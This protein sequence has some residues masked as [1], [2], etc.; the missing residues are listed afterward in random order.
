MDGQLKLTCDF[1][2]C[3]VIASYY[4]RLELMLADLMTKELDATKL[5]TLRDLMHIG[6]EDGQE[7]KERSMTFRIEE[8]EG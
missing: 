4:L 1:S 3:G 5:A 2:H 7:C 6:Y 8:K